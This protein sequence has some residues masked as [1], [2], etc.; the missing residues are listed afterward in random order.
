MSLKNSFFRYFF[1]LITFG[2]T[3]LLSYNEKSQIIGKRHQDLIAHQLITYNLWNEFGFLHYHGG[4]I[5]TFPNEGDLYQ[6]ND[7]IQTGKNSKGEYFYFS[8][9]PFTFYSTYFLLKI[10]H[11]KINEYS[12]RWVATFFL[13]L[14]LLA[15]YFLFKENSFLPIISYLFLPNV[16]WFHHNVWFVDIQIITFI[17]WGMYFS[18]HS[19]IPFLI[20][21]FMACFTE[22]WG[23]LWVFSLLFYANF[24][25]NYTNY[26]SIPIGKIL[27]HNKKNQ[28]LTILVTILALLFFIVINVSIVG[29]NEFYRGL[30]ERFILRMGLDNTQSDY[31][32]RFELKTYVFIA[33]YYLRNYLPLLVCLTCF[34][35]FNRKKFS[36]KPLW[37]LQI[38]LITSIFLHHFILLNW[39]AA[40]D[41]SVLKF[42]IVIPFL[43]DYWVQ[44]LDN[45]QKKV[46]KYAIFLIIPVNIYLYFR[47]TSVERYTHYLEV[48]ECIQKTYKPTE[49]T[50]A[51]YFHQPLP[52]LWWKSERIVSRDSSSLCK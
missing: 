34:Y 20:M 14:N 17:L 3:I 12:I 11:L 15:L 36:S 51:N 31:F 4:L 8:Y 13:F 45:L 1:I 7:P 52:Y 44:N 49:P 39:T 2:L 41:F 48:S 42:S 32:Q 16:L 6:K 29:I 5:L 18:M 24:M 27:F 10:L 43:V 19:L 9:P 50:K 47:H 21:V 40:H 38:P 26:P 33:W 46:F 37:G 30:L 25:Q 23:L 35:F 22:W 28:I